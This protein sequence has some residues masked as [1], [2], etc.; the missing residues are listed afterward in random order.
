MHDGQKKHG[1]HLHEE[2]A[3]AP[4]RAKLCR[5]CEV[6]GNSGSQFTL[7]A[8]LQDVSADNQAIVVGVPQD[9]S[10]TS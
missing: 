7:R 5:D 1:F 6:C 2:L 9:S 3:M 10:S 4:P 8:D